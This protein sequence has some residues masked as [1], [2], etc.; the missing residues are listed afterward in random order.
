MWTRAL[1][2]ASVLVALGGV[3]ASAWTAPPDEPA[4]EAPAEAPAEAETD[5]E[6]AVGPPPAPPPPPAGRAA[7]VPE[8]ASPS[9]DRAVRTRPPKR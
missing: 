9:A 4:V 8:A 6:D 3:A 5:V 2:L 7:P 1:L